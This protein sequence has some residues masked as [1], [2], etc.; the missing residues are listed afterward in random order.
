MYT[1][2]WLIESTKNHTGKIIDMASQMYSPMEDTNKN[3]K[4]SKLREENMILRQEILKLKKA[5]YLSNE[6]S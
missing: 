1:E 5:L 2:E 3:I 6:T 4:Q